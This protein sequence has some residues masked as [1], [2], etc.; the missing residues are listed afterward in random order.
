MRARTRNAD[1]AAGAPANEREVDVD[2]G[3]RLRTLGPEQTREAAAALAELLEPGDVVV[4]SGDLGAGKTCFVQGAARG[5]GVEA[6]VTSPTFS[7]VRTYP[8][9]RIPVVHCDVYRLD[10]LHDVLDLGEEVLARDVVTFVEWGDAVG[11][12][13]PHDRL[14]V[15]IVLE[16]AAGSDD[17]R[18][19]DLRGHGRWEALTD[20]VIERCGDWVVGEEG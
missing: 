17:V 13:L 6:R 7:L 15:D 3:I 12:L 11:A 14:D 9:G 1:V 18:L 8:D 19:L 16:D 20:R 10:R 2:D 5:L 4:L